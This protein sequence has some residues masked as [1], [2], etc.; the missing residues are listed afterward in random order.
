MGE[1][2]VM[3]L[4]LPKSKVTASKAYLYRKA[5]RFSGIPWTEFRELPGPI[6]SEYVAF[7]LAAMAEEA[8]AAGAMGG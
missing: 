6:Q 7:Y 4:R 5:A 2:P 3:E 8:I 1:I